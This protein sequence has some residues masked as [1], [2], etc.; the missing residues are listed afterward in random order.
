MILDVQL[1]YEQINTCLWIKIKKLKYKGTLDW[2]SR[3]LR[4]V[5]FIFISITLIIIHLPS[6]KWGQL[7]LCLSYHTII[8]MTTCVYET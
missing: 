5:H 7:L 8:S 3:Y 6:E 2:Y 4:N 1:F